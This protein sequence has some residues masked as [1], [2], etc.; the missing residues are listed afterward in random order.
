MP[1]R[2]LHPLTSPWRRARG[3]AQPPEVRRTGPCSRP[4]PRCST[5]GCPGSAGSPERAGRSP[6]SG[7]YRPPRWSRWTARR[8]PDSCTSCCGSSSPPG[9]SGRPTTA[10]NCSWAYG[11]H[12]RRCSPERWSAGWSGGRSPDG[13]CTTRCTTPGSPTCCW[14]GSA[15]PA[16]SVR[17]ASSGPPASRPV[18][19]PGCW[20]PSSPTPRSSTGT[21]SS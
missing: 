10:T 20:T 3:T 12:C 13:P 15:A 6:A 19:H 11:R 4:S 21:R 8:A 5:N 9:R 7:W 2:R 1:C 17:C 18:S 14:N 16:A